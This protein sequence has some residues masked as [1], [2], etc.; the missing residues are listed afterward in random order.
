MQSAPLNLEDATCA[1][2]RTLWCTP[3]GLPRF[4]S[5]F[6]LR[7]LWRRGCRLLAHMKR[8]IR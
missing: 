2:P 7:A 4:S 5:P 6:A 8:A 3:G 1:P